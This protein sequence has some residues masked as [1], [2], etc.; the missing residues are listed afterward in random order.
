MRV[1]LARGDWTTLCSRPTRKALAALVGVCERSI[2]TYTTLAGELEYL[3]VTEPGTTARIRAGRCYPERDPYAGQG[4]RAQEV[5][6]SVPACLR[7][8]V[9]RPYDEQQDAAP[10]GVSAGQTRTCAPSPRT[11]STGGEK[12]STHRQVTREPF[13]RARGTNRHAGPAKAGKKN[14]SPQERRRRPAGR[15][16]WRARLGEVQAIWQ[17]MPP[18]LLELLAGHEVPRIAEAIAVELEHRSV[19]ELAERVWRHWDYWKYKLVAGLVRSPAAIAFRLVR[20]D[21]DNCPD[22]R[23]EDR[24]NLDLDAPC[25]ACDQAGEAIIAARQAEH[26]AAR[27]ARYLPPLPPGL[28][29]PPATERPQPATLARE[30]VR[31]HLQAVQDG[32]EATQR[33]AG[34]RE[35]LRAQ[36]ITKQAQG[37]AQEAPGALV[38]AW[39]T[40]TQ[41]AAPP[42]AAPSAN[43]RGLRARALARARREKRSDKDGAA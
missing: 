27:H 6:I 11:A 8:E 39:A 4:N 30:E 28:E 18:E 36:W 32:Q 34:I 15:G 20:R 9:L 16:L 1:M 24:W 23:C 40:E 14:P 13:T 22:V 26:L 2:T 12:L 25:K 43:S 10:A 3:A 17:V 37:T 35:A 42:P 38:T 33:A 29:E 19:A 21:F 5:Q 41:R 7:E 31:R